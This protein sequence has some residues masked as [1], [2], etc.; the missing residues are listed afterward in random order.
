MKF[1]TVRVRFAPSPTGYLHIGGLRTALFNHLFARANGGT[2]VLRIEDTDQSRLVKGSTKNLIKMLQWAGIQID[3]GPDLI[4]T[5]LPASTSCTS[6]HTLDTPI[7]TPN[8]VSNSNSTTIATTTTD[9]GPYTQS[10]RLPIYQKYA[11]QLVDSGA[12]YPCFCSAA[13]LSLLRKSQQK[14]GSGSMM[15]DRRCRKLPKEEVQKRL[16]N[17]ESHT[18]RMYVPNKTTGGETMISDLILGDTIYSNSVI[19][20][21]ILIKSDGYPTY[22]LANVVDDHLMNIT[23]VIRGEEWLPSTPKHQLLYEALNWEV[24]IFAHLPLLLNSE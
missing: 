11:Q 7:S 3:E 18:I 21:Q 4:N 15:Y 20:D 2:F 9:Y 6:T 12:A 5:S 8:F 23:H 22:H 1:P 17:N 19:D 16:N 10:E 24:P 14:S 13:R